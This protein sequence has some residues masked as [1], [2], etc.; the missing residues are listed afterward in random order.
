MCYISFGTVPSFT[1]IA[2]TSSG[3]LQVIFSVIIIRALYEFYYCTASRTG[4]LFRAERRVYAVIQRRN[5]FVFKITWCCFLNLEFL[6]KAVSGSRLKE[7]VNANVT[8]VYKPSI[9]PTFTL[10]PS[11]CSARKA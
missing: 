9:I 11:Y 2:K 6:R 10:T 4:N 7:T 3:N 1:V 5:D 8:V